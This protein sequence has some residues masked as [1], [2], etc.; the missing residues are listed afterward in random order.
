MIIHT[1]GEG[2]VVYEATGNT[3]PLFH[4][5]PLPEVAMLKTNNKLPQMDCQFCLSGPRRARVAAVSVT[6]N[7]E[8]RCLTAALS[9][10]QP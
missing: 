3:D 6:A 8:D 5:P 9:L 4:L 7:S 10:S 1:H 2:L